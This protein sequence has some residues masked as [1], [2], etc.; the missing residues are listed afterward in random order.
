MLIVVLNRRII[1]NEPPFPKYFS[2]EMISLLKQLM[3]KDPRNRLGAGP[4]DALAIKKHHFFEV[5]PP[6]ILWMVVAPAV[7]I[8]EPISQ[9]DSEVSAMEGIQYSTVQGKSPYRYGGR[10]L[11]GWQAGWYFMTPRWQVSWFMHKSCTHVGDFRLL[12]ILYM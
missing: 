9:H 11:H 5:S 4:E 10:A 6:S 12:N 7:I 2:P 1:N 3:V 8:T